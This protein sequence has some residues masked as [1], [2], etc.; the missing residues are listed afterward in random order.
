[1]PGEGI[2][3]MEFQ[4]EDA[5]QEAVGWAKSNGL[6]IHVDDTARRI[7]GSLGGSGDTLLEQLTGRIIKEGMRQGIAM[8]LSGRRA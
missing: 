3:A 8:Q 6:V 7:T 5:V 2:T 1:M 4:F